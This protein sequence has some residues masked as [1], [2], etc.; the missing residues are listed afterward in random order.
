MP[1]SISKGVSDIAE[2]LTLDA[3]HV[4]ARSRRGRQV[5]GM[6]RGELEKLVVTL[7]EEMYHRRRGA[8]LRVRGEAPGRDQG[9]PPR[10]ARA[11]PG[12][13]LRLS[14]AGRSA[15]PRSRRPRRAT[16]APRSSA[17]ARRPGGRGA[18]G[19]RRAATG[20]AGRA[21]ARSR[22]RRPQLAPGTTSN[23]RRS[24]TVAWWMWPPRISS[25]P[26]PASRASSRLRPATGSFVLRHG[27][28]SS[29]W[30]STTTRSAPAGAARRRASACAR[31]AGANVAALVAP[32]RH[33]ADADDGEARRL[34]QGRDGAE[35]ALELARRG[36]SAGRAA[37]SGCRGCRGRRARGGPSARR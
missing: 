7:E 18:R 14:R 23:S 19:P 9:S 21:R 32:R 1:T 34:V 2:F 13:P 8:P 37:A 29:W 31:A 28:P 30:C 35:A 3:P 4:P 27:A 15:S 10:A 33:R 20:A 6:D 36:G 12:R 25:A 5:E 24:A 22:A 16:R 26:A 11:R 17:P